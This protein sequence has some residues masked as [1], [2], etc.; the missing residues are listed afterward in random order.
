[1]PSP[2]ID[3]HGKDAAMSMTL[4]STINGPWRAPA[5]SP[6]HADA[7]VA[8]STRSIAMTTNRWLDG[9][10]FGCGNDTGAYGIKRPHP[11]RLGGVT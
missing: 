5:S 4:M 8:A 2:T 6:R 9:S 1:M 10:T 3:E 11:D 7:T